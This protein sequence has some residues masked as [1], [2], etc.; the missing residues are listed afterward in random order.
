MKIGVV[1]LGKLGFPLASLF[2]DSG[3]DVVGYDVNQ[4]K[5]NEINDADFLIG[6]NPAL[7]EDR[8][9]VFIIT[10]TFVKKTEF[11]CSSVHSAFEIV[12]SV[13]KN[14]LIIIGSNVNI[15]T[16]DQLGK[17]HERICY[18][19][20]FV[21]QGSV[22]QDFKNPKFVIVGTNSDSDFEL[23]KRIWRHVHDKEIIQMVPVEAELAKNLSNISYSLGMTFANIVGDVCEKF[24]VDSSRILETIYKDHRPYKAGLGFMGPCFPDDVKYFRN[25]SKNMQSQLGYNFAH[26]LE[27]ANEAVIEKY[28][29]AIIVA[30][31]WKI[32]FLGVAYKPN[33]PYV[34]GSQPLML[35]NTLL[36]LGYTI[37]IF[38]ELAEN[39]AVQAGVSRTLFCKSA[40]ECISQSEVIFVGTPNYQKCKIPENIIVINPWK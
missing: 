36:T 29:N 21:K 2:H 27:K 22:Y 26:F 11:D 25:L 3:F 35:I 16:T 24:N 23:V 20:E 10:N 40:E 7:L 6:T 8:D 9:A 1:G 13:N 33:V 32:G 31:F 34:E 4:S 39:N 37:S 38:D 5:I 18:C 12:H 19:P 30:G 14:C 28:L 15:G 17:V